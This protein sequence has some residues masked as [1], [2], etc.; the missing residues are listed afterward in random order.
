MTLLFLLRS[1]PV[2]FFCLLEG[3]E[4]GGRDGKDGER[5]EGKQKST[6]ENMR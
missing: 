2:L 3:W 5:K 6:E 4:E 1:V